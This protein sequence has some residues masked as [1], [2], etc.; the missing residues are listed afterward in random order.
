[1]FPGYREISKTEG[2]IYVVGDIHGTL[3]ELEA[4]IDYLVGQEHLNEKDSL[5]FIGDYID[6]GFSSKH[7]I[8][9]LLTTHQSFPL[10]YFLR[11]NHEDMMIHYLG[12]QSS[13]PGSNGDNFIVN[14]G[15]TTLESYGIDPNSKPDQ[16]IKS[17]PE[18]HLD[19]YK[20]LEIMLDFPEHIFVHAGV[21]PM[22][23]LSMQVTE[24]LLWIRDDFIMS[25]H[26]FN[27]TI[28]FGHTPFK[29]IFNEVPLKLGIDTGLVYG[30]ILSCVEL[31]ELK[32]LQINA[33]SKVVQV[34]K[35]LED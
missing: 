34:S 35:I 13:V 12:I 33:G 5:V 21:D 30:N 25:N 7:V 1:M 4:L 28:V 3:P 9:L 14:G 2:R 16:I 31:K 24:N 26:N 19:F 29:D 17:L 11:G 18:D 15:D 32:A 22:R 8:D 20:N 6:R 27:K 23:D 10:T